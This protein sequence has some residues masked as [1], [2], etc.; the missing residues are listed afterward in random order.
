MANKADVL[1]IIAAKKKRL[2][3]LSNPSVWERI[4]RHMEG[5]EL[6]EFKQSCV[7]DEIIIEI[8]EKSLKDGDNK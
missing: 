2:K 4:T 1:R 7:D 3:D 5:G 6:R 8:L